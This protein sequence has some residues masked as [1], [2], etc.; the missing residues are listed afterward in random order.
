MSRDD[1]DWAVGRREIAS[2][3]AIRERYS[4]IDEWTVSPDGERLAAVVQD[5]D[6]FTALVNGESWGE[7]CELLWHLRYTPDGR[8][9]ALVRDDDEW[10]VA[11]DGVPWEQRFEY[12]WNPI[13]GAGPGRLPV[14]ARCLPEPRRHACRRHRAGRGGQGGRRPRLLR[15]RLERRGRR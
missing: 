13:L 15:R 2:L 6:G 11:V 5:G 14:A 1:W 4:R 8:L 3:A 9:V 7:S 12:A 10:T